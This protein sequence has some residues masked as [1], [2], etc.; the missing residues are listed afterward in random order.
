MGDVET[1]VWMRPRFA[2]RTASPARSISALMARASP[3][4][5]AALHLA[6]DLGDGLEIALAGDREAGLDD[7][8]AHG[9]K[10]VRDFELFLEAHRRAGALLAI[11]QRGVEDEDAVAFRGGYDGNGV[12]HGVSSVCKPG[13]HSRVLRA[14]EGKLL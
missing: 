11:A 1:K 5:V 8:D 4:T 9:V 2:P 13:L 3:A 10:K 6:S 14:L 12:G 7:V